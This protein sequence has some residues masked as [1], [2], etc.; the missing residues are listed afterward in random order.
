MLQKEQSEIIKNIF[1][2]NYG[3]GGEIVVVRAPGRVNL[4][5][6]HTDYND[7]FVFPMALDFCILVAARKRLDKIVKVF[8]ADF[9]E[10]VEFSLDSAIEYDHEKRWSNYPRGV[11]SVLREAGI[12]LSGM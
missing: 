6:E 12:S 4:I 9:D 10:M 5:G 3:D 2:K 11:L 8:S 1:R 7:G